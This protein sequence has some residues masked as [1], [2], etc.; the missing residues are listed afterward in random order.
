MHL[1]RFHN[2]QS[3]ACFDAVSRFHEHAND[4]AGH[5]RNDLLAAFR[6]ER[7][8]PA[9]TPSTRIGNL[10][11][12]LLQSS[13]DFENAA[14]RWGDANFVGLAFEKKRERVGRDFNG[15]GID[16]LAVE[17]DFPAVRDAFEFDDP[18]IS[19]RMSR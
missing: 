2:E 5:G 13:L 14:A 6:F 3:L 12:E 11:S 16:R 10:G 7:A 9:A 18:H 8:M 17:R 15:I 4:F 1:H 19:C